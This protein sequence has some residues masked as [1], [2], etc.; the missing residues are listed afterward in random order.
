MPA[1]TL[2]IGTLCPLWNDQS[3][4]HK[5]QAHGHQILHRTCFPFCYTTRVMPLSILWLQQITRSI[6]RSGI[7]V[8]TILNDNVLCGKTSNCIYIF[9]FQRTRLAHRSIV[10]SLTTSS[11]NTFLA[12]LSSAGTISQHCPMAHAIRALKVA[13]YGPNRIIL[14]RLSIG[15]TDTR[16]AP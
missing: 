3:I 7:V 10:S 11:R 16:L 15:W 1:A 8:S 13:I 14:Q 12:R 2:W 4:Y 6:L 9:L 5:L